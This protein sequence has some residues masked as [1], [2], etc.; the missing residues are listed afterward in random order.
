MKILLILPEFY[1]SSGGGII[2]FYVQ[3]IK[4]FIDKGIKP[5]ILVG[6]GSSCNLYEGEWEGCKVY[7]LQ[8][9]R[10][11]KFK[12]QF[13]KF[14]TFPNIQANLAAAWAMFEQGNEIGEFDIIECTD[15]GWGYIPWVINQ[16]HKTVIQF[17][18]SIGEIFFHDPIVGKE[19]EANICQNI[20]LQT[21][22]FANM[23][24]SHSKATQLSWEKL[25]NKTIAYQLPVYKKEEVKQEKT[26]ENL[27]QNYALVVG[28][29]QY[30]KG[31][32]VLCQ[33]FEI[34]KDKAPH[35]L[36]IGRNS[37]YQNSDMA[38]Y[39]AKNYPT[40]W[41]NKIKNVPQSDAKEIENYQLNAN[42]IIIPS[43]WD[44]FNFTCVEAMALGKVV[45]CSS[46]AGAADIIQDGINGFVFEKENPQALA[47][48]I[49]KVNNLL[50][51]EIIKIGIE[52]QITVLQK[53]NPNKIAEQRIELYKSVLQQD[54]EYK[55][56]IWIEDFIKPS[57]SPNNADGVLNNVP[58]KT[59]S[60]H[61]KERLIKKI[62]R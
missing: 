2:T 33:A 19:L 61:L 48:V 27:P 56:N 62:I 39:L 3:L 35:L 17:H 4:S 21:L 37:D 58:L 31:P 10:L 11:D 30:W 49:E 43:A 38:G 9:N 52:A 40:I 1:P 25:L 12:N 22:R 18:A 26:N 55:S 36:W 20:E 42:F 7:S 5:T 44:V 54:A 24:I 29:V 28:R 16:K 14:S 47:N 51:E 34:L 32:T 60:T 8:K 53:L 45:V 50:P 15:W 57:N 23:L 6:S 13:L 59:I 41:N 46:G